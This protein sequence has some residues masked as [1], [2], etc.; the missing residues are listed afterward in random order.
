MDYIELALLS[1]RTSQIL[2]TDEHALKHGK[3]YIN[4]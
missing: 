1:I 2:Q 3:K 4:K